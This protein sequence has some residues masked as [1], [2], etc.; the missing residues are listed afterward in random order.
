MTQ[1]LPLAIMVIPIMP[2]TQECVVLTGIS[3]HEAIIN[4]KPTEIVTHVM[5]YI[6]NPGLSS[7]HS[8]LAIPFRIVFDT[9]LPIRTNYS[10][11]K[12]TC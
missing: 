3:N 10:K 4:Q 9:L 12:N 5:P 6:N 11:L 2:P 8:E 1:R 7:K